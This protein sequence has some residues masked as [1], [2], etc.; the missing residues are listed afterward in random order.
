MLSPINF[1][2]LSKLEIVSVGNEKW[3]L[4]EYSHNTTAITDAALASF[5]LGSHIWLI[6]NDNIG[7]NNGESYTTVLKLTGCREGEFTCSDG[8]CIRYD[9]AEEHFSILL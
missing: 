9:Y 5:V 6:E 8:Q 4:T 7:C 1:K 3:K 2:L